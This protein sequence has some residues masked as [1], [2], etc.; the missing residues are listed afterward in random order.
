MAGYDD[1]E[2]ES[3]IDI[4]IDLDSETDT[5]GIALDSPYDFEEGE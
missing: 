2:L 3:P 4:Q 1:I 5:D